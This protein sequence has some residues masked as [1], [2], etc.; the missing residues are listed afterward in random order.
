MDK[1][2]GVPWKWDPEADEVAD[3]L[4]VRMLS[5]EE[6]NQLTGPVGEAERKT[7]YRMR[8]K[9]GDFVAKGFAEGCA[10]CK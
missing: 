8:L 5:D 7:V 6:K 10:G 2:R 9:K 3:K 4:L 1:I